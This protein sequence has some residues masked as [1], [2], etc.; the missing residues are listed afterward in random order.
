MNPLTN[1]KKNKIQD[2]KI[3]YKKLQ[4]EIKDDK[5]KNNHMIIKDIKE[6]KEQNRNASKKAKKNIKNDNNIKGNKITNFSKKTDIN[7]KT[8]I[9]KKI[10][11][12]NNNIIKIENFLK[13]KAQ[14][15]DNLEGK[16]EKKNFLGSSI[17]Y[18]LIDEFKNDDFK[19]K[20]N[21]IK[22][23]TNKI[24]IIKENKI[25]E[26]EDDIRIPQFN[27]NIY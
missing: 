10:S 9:N 4:L 13:S 12:N 2:N 14:Q 25:K 23:P 21:I 20:T 19:P 7:P 27:L 8:T 3:K 17:N 1:I 24:N 22:N 6:Q 15:N 11:I 5:R 18:V 26:E 16:K